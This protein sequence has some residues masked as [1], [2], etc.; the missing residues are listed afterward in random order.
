MNRRTRRSSSP[1]GRWLEQNSPA[2]FVPWLRNHLGAARDSLRRLAATPLQTGMTVAVIAIALGLPTLLL[3]LERLAVGAV[4]SVDRSSDINLFF[5]TGVERELVDSFFLDW[6]DDPRIGSIRLISPE[7][8]LLE[9]EQYSGLGAVLDSFDRNPLPW[10]ARIAPDP[11]MAGRT[12]DLN[13]LRATMAQE[14]GV[15]EVQLDLQWLER[16]DAILQFMGRFSVAVGLLLALGV[17]LIL[18]NTIRLTIENRRSEI[19][20]IKLVGGTDRYVSR[21]LLYTGFWYG[22]LGGLL[23]GLIVALV[24]LLIAGPVERLFYSYQAVEALQLKPDVPLF[25]LAAGGAL[26]GLLGAWLS[27]RQHLKAIEPR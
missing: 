8:G 7:Q 12:A 20:V 26:L 4:D 22:M 23:A 18:G 9:F 14:R 3:Q 2:R 10:A 24:S 17:V 1:L 15:A 5:E 25:R 19:L 11:G 6:R 27:V 21:P 16:L 13:I